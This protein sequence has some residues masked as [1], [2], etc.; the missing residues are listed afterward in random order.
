MITDETKSFA[1]FDNTKAGLLFD[2]SEHKSFPI[3]YYNVINGHGLKPKPDRSYFGFVSAGT[4]VLFHPARPVTILSKGMY[5]TSIGDFEIKENEGKMIVVEVLHTKGVYPETNYSAYFTTGGPIEEKGRL[6]YIDG[7]T[8]SLLLPPV[9]LGDP[10]FNHLHFPT[11]IDQTMHTHPS[12]RIGL[13]VSGEGLCITPFGNLKL[14]EGMIFVIKEWNG[15]GYSLGID[16]KQY[17]DGSH[18]FKTFED[19]VMNVVAFHPD[20]DFGATDTSHPMINRTMVNGVSA[21]EIESIRTK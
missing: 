5:F 13:V 18:S 21:S 9:K 3:A 15:L 2:E 7:C 11:N 4:V 20:S 6:K 12:H 8:D 10:C 1:C 16:G 14:T 17:E 19:K